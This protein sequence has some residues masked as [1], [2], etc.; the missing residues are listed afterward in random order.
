MAPPSP[1]TSSTPSSR[2]RPAK[3]SARTML[4]PMAARSS[5]LPRRTRKPC[6]EQVQKVRHVHVAIKVHIL[7]AA[8]RWG[9]TI[10][11]HVPI[12][13]QT[14]EVVGVHL[15]ITGVKVVVRPD[16]AG[17]GGVLRLWARPPTVDD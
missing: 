14:C 2:S 13:K 11:Q 17:A 5:T 6:V 3:P 4:P 12:Q 7:P 9:R 16:I 10:A 8:A 15:P 1:T